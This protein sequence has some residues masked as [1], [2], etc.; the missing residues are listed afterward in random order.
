MEVHF[1]FYAGEEFL[2]HVWGEDYY[3]DKKVFFDSGRSDFIQ[4]RKS[5]QDATQPIRV[6]NKINGGEVI[7][8]GEKDFEEWVNILYPYYAT[9][10]EK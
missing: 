3:C 4:L 10:F 2:A 9:I 6:M 5:I 1:T 8:N 7:L